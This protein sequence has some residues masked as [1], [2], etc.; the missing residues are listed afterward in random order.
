MGAA[1]PQYAVMQQ[2][3]RNVQPFPP[4]TKT[5]VKAF[6]NNATVFA[7]YGLKSDLSGKA[8]SNASAR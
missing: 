3:S 2:A 5:E 8:P 6:P 7:A 1:Q 4:E